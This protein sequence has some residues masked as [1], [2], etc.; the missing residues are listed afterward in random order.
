MKQIDYVKE[1]FLDTS[2]VLDFLRDDDEFSQRYID[3]QSTLHETNDLIRKSNSVDEITE[4]I[5]EAKRRFLLHWNFIHEHPDEPS[6]EKMR[7]LYY[8]SHLNDP[9]KWISE[10]LTTYDSKKSLHFFDKVSQ[11]I[12]FIDQKIHNEALNFQEISEQA[13]AIIH[14]YNLHSIDLSK[15]KP[16]KASDF[17]TNLD[18]K[19][20]DVCQSMGIFPDVI[21][22]HGTISFSA[23]PH[24]EAFFSPNKKSISIGGLMQ[25]SSTI[26]HEW[27]HAL[28]Y[29]VGNQ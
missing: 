3:F 23:T 27:I 25:N 29:H 6:V 15:I 5:K 7:A 19:L 26:L 12:K 17:L 4:H 11:G 28:D 18:L 16:H 2:Y 13:S 21:G 10:T 14:K 9:E 1:K 24:T 22:I 8:S 20:N